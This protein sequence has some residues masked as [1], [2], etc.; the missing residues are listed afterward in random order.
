[1]PKL[2]IKVSGCLRTLTGAEEFAAIHAAVSG[3]RARVPVVGR[4]CVGPGH[5]VKSPQRHPATPGRW[6]VTSP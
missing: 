5:L 3:Q 2:R 6:D 1:M 4:E